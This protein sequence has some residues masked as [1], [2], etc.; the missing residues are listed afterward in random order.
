MVRT[1]GCIVA[2]VTTYALILPA[3]TMEQNAFCGYEEHIHTE[4]CYRLQTEHSNLICGPNTLEIHVHEEGCFDGDGVLVCT[5]PDFL[6]HSHDEHCRDSEGA[7]ICTLPERQQHEHG[8]DCYALPE[9]VFH[10][11]SESC[12]VSVRGELICGEEERQGHSHGDVCYQTGTQ[13]LCTK[14]AGHQ[15]TDECYEH[16]L[17][18]TITDE[19]HTH[20]VSCYSQ[21]GKLI[22]PLEENHEH[23]SS[24]YQ[25]E[26]IC[27]IP[28]SEG[29][30]HGDGCYSWSQELGCGF[31]EGQQ[32]NVDAPPVCICTEPLVPEHIHA[33]GCFELT[34]VDADPVC[35]E[36]HEHSLGCYALDCTLE[37][38]SHSLQCYSDPQADVESPQ[39]WEATMQGVPLTGDGYQDLPAIA[40]SQLGYVESAR[41]Y[42]VGEDHSVHGYTRYGDWYSEPYG[43]WNAMFVSF[44]LHYAGVQDIPKESDASQW[45]AQLEQLGLYRS[46]EAAQPKPGCLVFFDLDEDGSGDHVGIVV[47]TTKA[48]EHMGAE[49]E[50][51]EGDVQDA[52]HYGRYAQSSPKI[53]G[54]GFLEKE[55]EPLEETPEETGEENQDALLEILICGIPAHMHGDECLDEEGSLSCPNQEHCHT[56]ACADADSPV[57][58]AKVASRMRA[59][60]AMRSGDGIQY[61]EDIGPL[62]SGV[63]IL[64]GEENIVYS[65]NDPDG[66]SKEITLGDMY[67]VQLTF[68]ETSSGQFDTGRLYYEVPSYL[69]SEAVGN[70]IIQDEFDNIVAYYTIVHNQM[71]VTPVGEENFFEIHN[72]T[73]FTVQLGAEAVFDTETEDLKIDFN[74]NYQIELNTKENGTLDARKELLE[75]DPLTR[76]LS[77]KCTLTAYGG[78]VDLDVVS[79]NWWAEGIPKEIATLPRATFSMTDSD[80][81]D[82]SDQWH[83]VFNNGEIWMTPW[84]SYSLGHRESITL[85]YKI[86]LSDQVTGNFV[87]ENS[88]NGYGYFGP[89]L[90]QDSAVV[91]T[92]IVFTNVEKS[93]AYVTET[94][95]DTAVDALEWT[96]KVANPDLETITITDQL[97]AGQ[98]FCKHEPLLIK[99]RKPGA[100]EKDRIQIAW[101]QIDCNDGDTRFELTL[102]EG[103]TEYELVYRSHY[104]LDPDD[105][106]IQNFENTVTTDVYIGQ[107]PTSGTASVGVMGVP[108][109]L[110]KQIIKSD[111]N[112]ITYQIDCFMPAALNNTVGVHLY[113]TLASWGDHEG[114][115]NQVPE[116]L[117]VTITPEGEEAYTFAPYNGQ[118]SADNTYLVRYD[119]QDFT[120]YFNT[121]NPHSTTSVWKCDKDSVLSISY[122]ISLDSL[123]LDGWSGNLT[124][125]TL[126]QFLQQTGQALNNQVKFNYSLKDFLTDSVRY[127]L[128][129]EPIPPLRK[130]GVPVTGEDGVFAYS[131]WFNTGDKESSIFTQGKEGN[132]PKNLVENLTLTDAFDPRLEYVEDSLQVSLWS[133]WNHEELLATYVLKAD[134]ELVFTTGDDGKRILTVSPEDLICQNPTEKYAWLDNQ[135]LMYTLQYLVGGYQ[136]EFTYQLRVKDNVKQTATEGVLHLENKAWIDWT[137][138]DG[139]VR[140]TAVPVEMLYDTGIIDKTM[141]RPSEDS[142]TANF[143][144]L[145]N[146]HGLDLAPGS[147]TYILHDIMSSNLSLIYKSLVIEFLNENGTVVA[148]RT[149]EQCSFAYN[150]VENKMTFTL[151]DS[152]IIRLQYD[153][154]VNSNGGNTVEVGNT[155]YLEGYSSIQDIV[156]ADFLIREHSGRVDASSKTF[157]LQKQDAYTFQPLPG[158]SFELYGDTERS[159]SKTI[160]VGNKTL[161]YYRTFTTGPNGM[162]DIGDTQLSSEH[163]YALKEVA[164]L[165]GY[166]A[167]KEPYLFYMEWAPLG[168]SGEI[169]V[170]AEGAL[171]VIRNIPY[172][173]EL[174]KT[175]GHGIQWYP[176]AGLA[177]I[178]LGLS[179]EYRRRRK[180]PI[181]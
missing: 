63:V 132:N 24:C 167:Q 46:R 86:Q 37:E 77:Y 142:N 131:V 6:V 20:E 116:S 82:I 168:A 145:V 110:D 10:S 99:A 5:Q 124:R 47:K 126:R 165:P 97:G 147:D 39:V 50:T 163:L 159:G 113:D 169:N 56:I 78:S 174:P 157:V 151:P 68:S 3:I 111:D 103:Y 160:T 115:V 139:P 49:I 54:Y 150:P 102:P 42:R 177:L 121:S 105:H 69:V 158:V 130:S 125:Q 149:P 76:T 23:D 45:M 92:P 26:Q 64:D 9:P 95:N 104:T 29:H 136:Y 156:H 14:P 98:T 18:C 175:G 41:N 172:I 22:C 122:R 181:P 138:P 15:H 25:R 137:G 19:T 16:P 60:F 123:M 164:P 62:L 119:G 91:K 129:K 74:G 94:V 180:S 87:Y 90:V 79:D 71:V 154:R 83:I 35:G 66:G 81:N 34:T 106:G 112:W 7:L 55:T 127:E 52:V 70:G 27:A 80:G 32:E 53:L 88:F 117:T 28:E 161:Y 133:Y 173:Y 144:I 72:D 84:Q 146:H 109:T 140:I 85:E 178:L 36:E 38:H 40:L 48:S 120:M 171:V 93:G 101:D 118:E 135:S 155:V 43:D 143:S 153:C 4:S 134:A 65:S 166:Q 152:T 30:S 176:M 12:Y 33:D 96:V 57:G 13:L 128:P 1:M 8:E 75:Y 2:F 11:H 148:T 89:N 58:Y 44:C 17:V 21:E 31:E 107:Q 73:S 108:P 179:C 100:E 61:Y 114:Y 67:V 141:D 59:R 162:V 51:V 170:V